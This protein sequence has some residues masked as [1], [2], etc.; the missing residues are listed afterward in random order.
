MKV[1]V[2]K[3]EVFHSRTVE[4]VLYYVATLFSACLILVHLA[5]RTF[6]MVLSP[7]LTTINSAMNVLFLFSSCSS[8]RS[9]SPSLN[10]DVL[11]VS[12]S[13]RISA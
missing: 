10:L 9:S 7:A 13:I 2:L 5:T 8:S 6:H 1:N 4:L 3:Q 11:S 12:L